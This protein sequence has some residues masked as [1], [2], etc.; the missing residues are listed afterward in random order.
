MKTEKRLSDT[1]LQDSIIEDE[2]AENGLVACINFGAGEYVFNTVE[3]FVM[4]TKLNKLFAFNHFALYAGPQLPLKK[5][6]FTAVTG[7]QVVEVGLDK[8]DSWNRRKIEHHF[9][10]EK[11]KSTKRMPYETRF[12]SFLHAISNLNL[13]RLILVCHFDPTR[14]FQLSSQSFAMRFDYQNGWWLFFNP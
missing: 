11:D 2:W 4:T 7:S 13:D 1:I 10:G 8:V 14:A 6:L 3:E 5:K 9:K 12:D